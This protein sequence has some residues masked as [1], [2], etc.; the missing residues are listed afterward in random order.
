MLVLGTTAMIALPAETGPSLAGW[1]VAITV[2]SLIAFGVNA[3]HVTVDRG[4]GLLRIKRS[5]T[6]RVTEVRFADIVEVRECRGKGAGIWIIQRA[7]AD[8]P[9]PYAGIRRGRKLY[10]SLRA[11]A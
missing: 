3:C 1:A 11:L 5:L 6:R 2:V 7:G 8:V 10:A 9:I 4:A